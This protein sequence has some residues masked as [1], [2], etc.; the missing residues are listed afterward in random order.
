VAEAGKKYCVNCGAEIDEKA[1]ICP[2][3]GVRQPEST[4]SRQSSFQNNTNEYITKPKKDHALVSF[5]LGLIGII[6]WFIPIIGFPVT[7]IGLIFG[8]NS[9][10]GK[11]RG[12]ALAGVILCTIF[13][14]ATGINS[15]IGA[16]IGAIWFHY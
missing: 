1:E 9:L 10:K 11:K 16:Y 12:M 2:K 4:I 5:I 6:A 7:I 14:L 13:L 8:I 15:I 3:C